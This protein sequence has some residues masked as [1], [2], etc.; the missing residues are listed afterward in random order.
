M[1]VYSRWPLPFQTF[2]LSIKKWDS[3][4]FGVL[5]WYVISIIYPQCLRVEWRFFFAYWWAAMENEHF[6]YY[7]LKIFKNLFAIAFFSARLLYIIEWMSIHSLEQCF[8]RDNKWSIHQTGRVEDD[9]DSHIHIDKRPDKRNNNI[10]FCFSWG[11]NR[12]KLKFYSSFSLVVRSVSVAVIKWTLTQN[13]S[14]VSAHWT[15]PKPSNLS[16]W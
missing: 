13:R 14:T 4:C 7:M 8:H 2:K 16:L 11:I 1:I 5:M 15:F 12:K 9:E 3:G 6:F 10:L